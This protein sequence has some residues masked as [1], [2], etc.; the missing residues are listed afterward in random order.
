MLEGPALHAHGDLGR[1][2]R[3]CTANDLDALTEEL[4]AAL[5]EKRRTP[6]G[7]DR[8]PWPEAGEYWQGQFR[9]FAVEVVETL[10]E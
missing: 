4:A 2:C 9:R 1:R 6:D 5:W 3:L 8:A 10:R 7:F